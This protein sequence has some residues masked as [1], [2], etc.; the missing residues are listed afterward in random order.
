MCVCVVESLS[1]YFRQIQH[2][3]NESYAN[4]IQIFCGCTAIVFVVSS[5]SSFRSRSFSHHYPFSSPALLMLPIESFSVDDAQWHDVLSLL[6]VFGFWVAKAYI[7]KCVFF[8]CS[9]AAFR[10]HYGAYL[11]SKSP[12]NL[13]LIREREKKEAKL[14]PEGETEIKTREKESEKKNLR[15]RWK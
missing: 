5:S 3:S 15:K 1:I 10:L 8:S 11:C 9:S 13:L 14:K 2:V 12:C 6:F 7:A 4:K